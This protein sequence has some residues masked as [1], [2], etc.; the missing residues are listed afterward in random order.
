METGDR[1]DQ[2]YLSI[3]QLK[4]NVPKDVSLAMFR[5]VVCNIVKRKREIT[6]DIILVLFFVMSFIHS[7]KII[8]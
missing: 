2:R 5:I 8:E 3:G 7:M 1:S 6:D 4:C